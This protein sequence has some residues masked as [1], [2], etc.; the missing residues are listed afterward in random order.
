[1]SAAGKR[2]LAMIHTLPCVIHF[3]C[4]AQMRNAEEAHHLEFVR[5]EHSDFATIPVC[6]GCH[7]ELHE[8][9]RRAFYRAHKL[10]DVKLLAWTIELVQRRE[11]GASRVNYLVAG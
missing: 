11:V 7:E 4:Y 5:G 9:R 10:D 2:H 1:M 8:M 6:K 3:N